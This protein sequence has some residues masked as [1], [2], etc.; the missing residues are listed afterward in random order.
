[1]YRSSSASCLTN[2]SDNNAIFEPSPSILQYAATVQQLSSVLALEVLISFP[3]LDLPIG[4][5]LVKIRQRE[6]ISDI[7]GLDALNSLGAALL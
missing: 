7:V 5:R 1:M 2:F 3:A 4:E 6:S